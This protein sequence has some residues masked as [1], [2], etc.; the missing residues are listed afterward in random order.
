MGFNSA[1]KSF[2]ITVSG[3]NFN[4]VVA[5]VNVD[6]YNLEAS[7]ALRVKFYFHISTILLLFK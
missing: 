3:W 4:R 2:K 1:F 6:F 5:L 7:A